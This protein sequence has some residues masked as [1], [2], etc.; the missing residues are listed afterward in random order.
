MSK[1]PKRYK[2]NA[3]IGDL[4]RSKRISSD[5]EKEKCEIRQKFQK[6]CYP[7]KF[8]E[9]IINQFE[10]KNNNESLL[11]PEGF[12]EEKKPFILFEIP[13]CERNEETSK[14][15]MKKFQEFTKHKYDTAVKWLTRKTHSLFKLKDQDKHQS[16]VVYE[17]LC[18]CGENYIGETVR[19][20]TIRWKEHENPKHKTE[21]GK[22]L[23]TNPSHSFTWSILSM[24]P[25]HNKSR[26]ILE[27][28]YIGTKK[29]TLN[30]QLETT[31]LQLFRNGV[32]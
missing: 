12:F 3:I 1:I 18:S 25:K 15:F 17:G 31:Q 6:A 28:L 20:A 2:R 27:A 13:F 11:I 21:P 19:N 8:T 24:A 14:R 23:E 32:T 16:S 7:S 29:P 4:N 22:H 30:N 5:F 9:S 26:K 10:N